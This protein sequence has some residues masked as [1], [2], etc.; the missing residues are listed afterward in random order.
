MPTI[1]SCGATAS[2]SSQLGLRGESDIGLLIA[3]L[4]RLPRF[5]ELIAN[6]QPKAQSLQCRPWAARTWTYSI[7]AIRFGKDR[8]L[9]IGF[10][11]TRASGSRRCAAIS[12]P[13][14]PMSC[15]PR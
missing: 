14:S 15:A 9:L 6:A 13:T 8:K 10:D 4:V 1:A 11:V 5:A 12:S 3:N 2:P 7:E